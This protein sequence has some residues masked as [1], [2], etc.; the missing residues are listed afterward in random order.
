[1]LAMDGILGI[2][3]SHLQYSTPRDG[4]FAVDQMIGPNGE[5]WGTYNAMKGMQMVV[6]SQRLAMTETLPP[7]IHAYGGYDTATGRVG[8][9]VASFGFANRATRTVH[10]HLP[11]MTGNKRL[12]RYLVDETHSSRWDTY[13]D[14]PAGIVDQDLVQLE[15]RTA[16]ERAAQHRS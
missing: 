13:Q 4:G 12:R 7:G 8:V 5:Q 9:V 15:D 10:L 6:G 2:A 11:G 14:D 1:M 3:Y 16:R